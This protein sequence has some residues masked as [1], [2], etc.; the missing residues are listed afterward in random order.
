MESHLQVSRRQW[1]RRS[2]RLLVLATVGLAM[3]G[4]CE[5]DPEIPVLFDDAAQ[6]ARPVGP[7]L[8]YAPRAAG[9]STSEQVPDSKLSYDLE[10]LLREDPRFPSWQIRGVRVVNQEA[11]VMPVSYTH[12]R[13][14][15][16]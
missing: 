2:R 10:G 13:A 14:H 7:L 3:A 11:W 12:L 16:T 9:G 15:E 5:P 8:L 6:G 1:A 4:G